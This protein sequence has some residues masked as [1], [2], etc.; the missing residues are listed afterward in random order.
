MTTFKKFKFKEAAKKNCVYLHIDFAGG[1]ADTDHP[2]SYLIKDVTMTNIDEHLDEVN[3]LID[4]FKKLKKVLSDTDI[5]YDEVLSEYGEEVAR[6]YDNAPN[7]PQCDYQYKCYLSSMELHG[8]D[9]NGDLYIQ[10][11]R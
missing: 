2:E 4:T 6:L 8:Y 9:E 7:D 3:H 10:Y 11:I 5:E 1:D